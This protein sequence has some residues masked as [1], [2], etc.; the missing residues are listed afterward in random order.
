MSD[1]NNS[2]DENKITGGCYCGAIRY[3]CDQPPVES[4][5][6]HCRE[7]QRWTGSAFLAVAGT[8]LSG[9]RYTKGSPKLNQ[10][11]SIVERCFCPDCGSSLHCRYLVNL[12]GDDIAEGPDHV[13][14]SIGTLDSPEAVKMEYHWGV[15]SQLPWVHFDDDLPR[16]RCDEA[17][18]LIRA[19]SL[20]K[21]RKARI[22]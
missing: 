21:E 18:E 12:G 9:F 20:A 14:V 17:P 10:S 4:G 16:T 2:N 1:S 22:D 7:C 8:P 11:S 6:C 3:E 13:L 15:E 19:L 5:L